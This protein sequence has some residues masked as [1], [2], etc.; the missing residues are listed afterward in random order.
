[1]G[2]VSMLTSIARRL[3]GKVA[4]ITGASGIGEATAKLF[5]CHGAYV[6]IVDV[7]DDKGRALCESLGSFVAYYIHCDVTDESRIQDTFDATISRHG[8][9]DIMFNNAGIISSPCMQI[10]KSEKADF[11]RVVGINLVGSYLGTKHA[12]RVMIPACRGSI[13]MTARVASVEPAMMPVAYTC[14]KHAVLGLMRSAAVELGQFGVR[15]NCMSLYALATSLA[16]T[17]FSMGGEEQE[18]FMHEHAILKGVRLKVEDIAEAVLFLGSEEAKYVSGLNL[19]VDGGFTIT[20]P[21]H[22]LFRYSDV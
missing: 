1:M 2:M 21:S 15:V 9:L 20:N 8:K 17:A 6:M 22:G 3:G 13:V 10:L 19:L 16:A 18:E 14:S 5:I 12:A 11:E 7:Q 4:L